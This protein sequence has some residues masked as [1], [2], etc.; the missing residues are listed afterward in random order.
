[1][2]D[3]LTG[4]APNFHRAL[5]D[6]MLF[7]PPD[8]EARVGLTDGNIRHL[9]LVPARLLGRRPLPG[10]AHY[11]TPVTGPYLCGAGTHRGG[12]HGG[13]GHH[14]ARAILAD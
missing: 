6:W 12:G 3:L 13:P 5:V 11:R 2:T 4:Y 10:S 1:M 9:D 7:T 8:L 14:A